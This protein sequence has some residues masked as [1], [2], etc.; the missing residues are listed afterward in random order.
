M[1]GGWANTSLWTGQWPLLLWNVNTKSRVADRSVSAPMTLSD[2]ERRDAR[3]QFFR[4]IYLITLVPFDGIFLPVILFPT[5]SGRAQRAAPQFWGSIL[6]MRTQY[7][8]PQNY[9]IWRGNTYGVGRVGGQPQPRPKEWSPAALP[10]V[11]G[12]LLSVTTLC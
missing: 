10:N 12:S 9:Q 8:S 4:R 2:L 3:G 6:F 5:A 7:S 1:A 11:W